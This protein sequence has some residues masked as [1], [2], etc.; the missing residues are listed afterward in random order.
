MLTFIDLGPSDPASCRGL[1]GCRCQWVFIESEFECSDT[2]RVIE[3]N[4]HQLPPT[5]PLYIPVAGLEH[6][7]KSARRSNSGVHGNPCVQADSDAET[8]PGEFLDDSDAETVPSEMPVES[9]TPIPDETMPVETMPYGELAT[10][11]VEAM[12]VET[13]PYGELATPLVEAMPVEAMPYGELATP[14]VEAMPVETLPYEELAAT[15]VKTMPVETMPVETIS[16][17]ELAT[18]PIETMPV[19]KIPD[20]TIRSEPNQP[21]VLPVIASQIE[22]EATPP[23][24]NS[25]WYESMLFDI[26]ARGLV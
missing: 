15:P 5:H 3:R 20:E 25:L 9:T 4:R 21:A 11:L 14:L 26:A 17:E 13:M 6:V 8:L 2:V 24:N 1:R 23:E 22:D 19:Q 7:A 16:D 18:T 12:P 10:P